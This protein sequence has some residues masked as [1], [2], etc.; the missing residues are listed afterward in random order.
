MLVANCILDFEALLT[1]HQ[2]RRWKTSSLGIKGRTPHAWSLTSHM[3]HKAS[4]TATATAT[5]L[6]V[7]NGP[8][9]ENGMAESMQVGM[10]YLL[11]DYTIRM[12]CK[13][14]SLTL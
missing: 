5:A 9:D 8:L 12:A 14:G 10:S 4:A 3:W 2:A 13:S 6:R 7:L 1:H 11:N